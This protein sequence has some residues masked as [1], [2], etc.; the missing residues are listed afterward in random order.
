MNAA[1][2]SP[3]GRSNGR[4]QQR[5]KR[6]RRVR[7]ILIAVA[8]IAAALWANNTSRWS[9][10][11]K[12]PVLL[13]HRGMAQTYDSA[14][15]TADTCTAA[16]I[17][18]PVHG[19]L[20]NTIASMRAAFQAGA[21]VVEFDVHPTMDGQF[22]VFHDWTLD[23]RTDGHGVTREAAMTALKKL[24]VGYGYTADG[25]KTYPFRGKG[26]GLMPTLDEVLA[27]FPDRRF[28]IHIKSNDPGEG[29][30]L[31]KRLAAL[32]PDRLRR[33][34]VYGGDRPVAVVRDRVPAIRTLSKA[35]LK[36]CALR[37][38]L[39]GWSGYVPESCSR[40]LLLVPANYGR[41]VWGWPNRFVERMTRAN[42]EVFVIGPYAGGDFSS[43]IDTAA[44]LTAIPPGFAGGI[45]TNRIE[46]IA[47]LAASAAH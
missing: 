23:C 6:M 41:W 4:E 36:A 33:L 39:L 25:G 1:P 17:R 43:G 38:V 29:E 21:D 14:N 3:R 13:A 40:S 28:L 18:P 19:Y 5:T 32:P 30:T 44:E 9:A 16:R 11:A 2:I 22:A 35:T 47:P 12:K 46:R 15:L 31:A 45:W 20:E 8:V 24:D 7:S 34:M 26:V 37:Y 27:E 42:S 10:T